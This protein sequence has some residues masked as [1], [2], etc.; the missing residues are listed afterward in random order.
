MTELHYQIVRDSIIWL[1][2]ILA[3]SEGCKTIAFK[4][5]PNPNTSKHPTKGNKQKIIIR[6][7][8]MQSLIVHVVFPF[9]IMQGESVRVYTHIYTP[10]SSFFFYICR[11]KIRLV[12]WVG[13]ITRLVKNM[14]CQRYWRGEINQF[15]I[16]TDVLLFFLL[17]AHRQYWCVVDRHTC[18]ATNSSEWTH[19]VV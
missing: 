16:C 18:I 2:W 19:V 1:W 11:A 13:L 4:G 10:S 15:M 5:P 17:Q 8:Q 14:P 12:L 6:T 9:Q 3:W 7:E